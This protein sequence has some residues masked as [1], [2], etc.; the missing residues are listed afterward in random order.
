MSLITTTVVIFEVFVPRCGFRNET[1]KRRPID[2][3]SFGDPGA[4]VMWLGR[5]YFGKKK[6]SS[7][8][9]KEQ[10]AGRRG[11]FTQLDPG[12]Q[13]LYPITL[14]DVPRQTH[15]WRVIEFWTFLHGSPRNVFVFLDFRGRPSHAQCATSFAPRDH[16][17]VR[18]CLCFGESHNK[19]TSLVDE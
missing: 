13:A 16:Y 8:V 3:G 6:A 5:H 10:S 12:C 9:L 4:A 11:V 7:V 2:L 17:I 18:I 15:Y 19:M 14:D 1:R